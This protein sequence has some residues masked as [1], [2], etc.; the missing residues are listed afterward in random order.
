[1]T[2]LATFWHWR[3][4]LFPLHR[5]VKS[6]ENSP[7]PPH[8]SR[9]TTWRFFHHR[10]CHPSAFSPRP[11]L[12]SSVFVTCLIKR[13]HDFF[14]PHFP[15]FPFGKS[16][17]PTHIARFVD[18]RRLDV[19]LESHLF[20]TNFSSSAP[21]RIPFHQDAPSPSTQDELSLWTLSLIRSSES[22]VPK[23]RV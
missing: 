6:T 13:C 19:N 21:G 11:I 5:L 18:R 16:T 22:K 23:L 9:T 20:L 4:R 17:L 7:A 15:L 1:M 14:S 2:S 8:F 10:I 12:Q 3:V